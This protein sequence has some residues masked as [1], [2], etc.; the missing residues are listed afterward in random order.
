MALL[1]APMEATM[2]TLELTMDNSTMATLELTMDKGGETDGGITTGTWY[3]CSR[4]KQRLRPMPAPSTLAIMALLLLEVTTEATMATLEVTMDNNTIAT[5]ELT[6]D[7][8]TMATLELTLDK[9]G[10]TDGG[11]T[12]GTRYLCSRGKRRLTLRP[13]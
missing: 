3:L 1:E 12:T 9:G 10:E 13:M 2:A 5:L 6:M 7:N 8:S 4:E 11:I